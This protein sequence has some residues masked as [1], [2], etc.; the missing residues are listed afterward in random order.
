MTNCCVLF[1]VVDIDIVFFVNFIILFFKFCIVSKVS[2]KKKMLN[3]EQYICINSTFFSSLTSSSLEKFSP[4][5]WTATVAWS[6]QL[7][8][9]KGNLH[10]YIKNLLW[11]FKCRRKFKTYSDKSMLLKSKI[12]GLVETSLKKKK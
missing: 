8:K 5:E 1:P 2:K 10:R 3:L 7:Q 11:D 9:S 4:K 6:N 12:L